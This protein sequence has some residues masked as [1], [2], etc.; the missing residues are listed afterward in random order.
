LDSFIVQIPTEQ[1]TAFTNVILGMVCLVLVWLLQRYRSQDYLRVRCWQALLVFLS[2]AAFIGA[3]AHGVAISEATYEG[4][5]KP[6]LLILGVVIA[7]MAL[8]ALYDL[9]GAVVLWRAGPLLLLV[10]ILFFAVTHLEGA[11]F[12][13]FILYQAIGMFFVFYVYVVLGVK[14]RLRG[15]FVIAG[16]VVLQLVAGGIQASGPFEVK[17]IWMFDHNGIFHM[18][19]LVATCVMVWGMTRGFG[20][21]AAVQA[22]RIEKQE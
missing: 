19:G 16:G 14:K 17:C 21:S 18:V 4:L 3:F 8:V 12:L 2:I 11:T 10:A 1:T 20:G 5:W 15:A 22:A 9:Y 13:V 6:L 7:N